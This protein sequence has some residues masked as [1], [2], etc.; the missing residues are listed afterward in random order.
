MDLLHYLENTARLRQI[1]RT[2]S[3]QE[4]DPM[5]NGAL[6]YGVHFPV[7][8]VRSTKLSEIVLDNKKF[9]A[10]RREWNGNDR[11]IPVVKPGMTEAEMVPI[12]AH[13]TIGEEEIQ[14]HFEM[15]DGEEMLIMR[16]LGADIEG[17]TDGLV[18][19]AY[20]RVERDAFTGWALGKVIQDDPTTGNTV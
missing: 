20:R 18:E 7:Q 8:D 9:V 4:V 15:M 11:L 3:A 13:F 6:E 16:R 14:R 12:G 2:V 17:R 10:S 1:D 5:D 19:A